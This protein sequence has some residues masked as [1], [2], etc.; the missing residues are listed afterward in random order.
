MQDERKRREENTR[1][2]LFRI[3]GEKEKRL[4]G[5]QKDRKTRRKKDEV[6][7]KC[8]KNFL[9]KKYPGF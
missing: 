6:N 3:V 8:M 7:E 1:S 2:T 5:S 4:I 9:L